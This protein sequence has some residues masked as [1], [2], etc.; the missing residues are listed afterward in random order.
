M[1]T[2]SEGSVV[3]GPRRW[4]WLVAGG[5]LLSLP[6]L[7]YAVFNIR[8]E[9]ADVTRW[10]PAATEQ[11]AQYEWF[12]SNFGID[13]YL[14]ASWEGCTAEDPRLTEFAI[15]L[16]SRFVKQANGVGVGEDSLISSVRTTADV[17]DRLEAPP[18]S[19]PAEEARER[20]AGWL[21]G[22]ET[23]T[24]AVI[25][26]ATSE[27]KRRNHE[28]VDAIQGIA[29]DRIGLSERDLYLGGTLFEA[30]TIDR[31][32]L[33]SLKRYVVPSGIL[34]LVLAFI[35]VRN[36]RLAAVMLIVSVYAQLL[37]VAVVFYSGGSLDAALVIMPTLVYVITMSGSLHLVNYYRHAVEHAHE[38]AE[39]DP[40]RWTLQHGWR[41]CATA[42]LTT[43][44]GLGSLMISQV[45]PV[46]LFGLYSAINVML[47][48]GVMLICVPSALRLFSGGRPLSTK[49]SL[50]I[51]L[52]RS[53]RMT[54][55]L[56][57][58]HR[59][60]N[61]LAVGLVLACSFGLTRLETSLN[62]QDMFPEKSRLVRNYSWLEEH[63]GPLIAI[64][65]VLAFS[66]DAEVRLLDQL[67]TVQDI[68]RRMQRVPEV[69]ATMSAMTFAPAL[70]SGQTLTSLLARR[71]ALRRLEDRLPTFQ[72]DGVLA[73]DGDSRLWR[74]TGQV[75]ALAGFEYSQVTARIREEI[76]ALTE[77]M[78][79][80]IRDSLTVHDTGLTPIVYR[81][82]QQML[83]DLINSF[84]G[85]FMLICPLMMLHVGSVH[86]GL[87]G[88]IP[89]VAPV[90]M[91]FGLL[92][93]SNVAVDIGVML[94]A[95]VGLGIAVDGT[96]HFVG[97]YR[98]CMHRGMDRDDA[99]TS[100]FR[101]CATAMT[102]TTLICGLGMLI[103]A[104]SDFIPMA[105]FSLILMCL[106]MT[107]L[108]GDLVLIPALIAGPLGRVLHETDSGEEPL[109]D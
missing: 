19:L 2:D 34:V 65:I 92:G 47:A 43:A 10:L 87:I 62:L 3:I 103:F 69:E 64:E 57:R 49:G 77:T 59:T 90:A 94:T 14:I 17:L 71:V 7:L 51:N 66:H 24:A 16:R 97:W 39:P 9:T 105:R 53:R 81:A 5:V 102:Q 6:W 48:L 13:D 58:R 23:G 29:Q 18:L 50:F 20:I 38:I 108:A 25:I 32:S 84:L 67:E 33:A 44:L 74:I 75:S 104:L 101:T 61:C 41:P 27:G 36:V 26:K 78:P 45:R 54:G 86:G 60:I 46:R 68:E 1:N 52:R 28:L 55:W 99:L 4:D 79:P 93:W 100:V 106:L 73:D 63:V 21:L 96:L 8:S 31:E 88:M 72:E 11:R 80:A 56:T 82:Q 12:V 98:G 85:A 107:A 91:V 70:P 22:K 37:A 109:L 76:D 35:A 40:A 30:V 95:S 15:A 42:N 89:N 83:T